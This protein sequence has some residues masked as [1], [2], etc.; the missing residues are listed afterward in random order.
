MIYD[1]PNL[2]PPNESEPE[3]TPMI[4]VQNGEANIV[5]KE[6]DFGEI[7]LNQE[8]HTIILQK[9]LIENLIKLLKLIR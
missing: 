6:D 7:F 1:N 8:G 9:S 4:L 3:Y 2:T 5:I